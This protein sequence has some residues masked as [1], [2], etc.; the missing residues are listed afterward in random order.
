MMPS[1]RFREFVCEHEWMIY[2]ASLVPLRKFWRTHRECIRCKR[3]ERKIFRWWFKVSK[4]AWE[5]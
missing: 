2:T 1:Q 5:G 4:F 3:K